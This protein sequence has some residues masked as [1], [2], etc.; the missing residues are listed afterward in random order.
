MQSESP[1]EPGRMD[2]TEQR[3][4]LTSLLLSTSARRA[5]SSSIA[6]L[7]LRRPGERR[8]G[9]LAHAAK[10]PE[11]RALAS[12]ERQA[13]LPLHRVATQSSRTAPTSRV[14]SC[15]RKAQNT[16]PAEIR[17]GGRLSSA[18]K[19]P[20][21]KKRTVQRASSDPPP[22]FKMA[23]ICLRLHQS[24]HREQTVAEAQR[25]LGEDVQQSA[26]PSSFTDPQRRLQDS[27]LLQVY[28]ATDCNKQVFRKA[29]LR[30]CLHHFLM[31][32][33]LVQHF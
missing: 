10:T 28:Y 1:Q 33:F 25:H 32:M 6:C 23:P 13:T 30:V 26:A 27:L 3:R 4:L 8:E 15:S 31:T 12:Q 19:R 7:C 9:A 5:R 24:S 22:G 17:R 29:Y 2:G 11:H 21:P 14:G 20:P 18:E 16:V